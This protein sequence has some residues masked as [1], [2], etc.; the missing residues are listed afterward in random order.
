ME[1]WRCGQWAVLSAVIVSFAAIPQMISVWLL[2]RGETMARTGGELAC[3][4]QGCQDQAC[5]DQGGLSNKQVAD[6]VELQEG[7]SGSA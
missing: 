5:Q 3:Q 7:D 2:L 4:D 1:R 6:E